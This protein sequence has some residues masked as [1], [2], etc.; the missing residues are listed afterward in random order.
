MQRSISDLDVAINFALSDSVKWQ[1]WSAYL[2]NVKKKL[3][4]Y[5]W[6]KLFSRQI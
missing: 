1:S 5:V 2:F 6:Q 3:N 4:T